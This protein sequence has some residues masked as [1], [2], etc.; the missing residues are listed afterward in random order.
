[1][2]STIGCILVYG[3]TLL[4]VLVVCVGLT[5]RGKHEKSKGYPYR[6]YKLV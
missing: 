4:Y 1:M 2:V 6:V 5:G 3:F